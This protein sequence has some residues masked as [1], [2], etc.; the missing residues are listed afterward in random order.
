M[1]EVRAML[2]IPLI[3]VQLDDFDL[4]LQVLAV[5]AEC[6]AEVLFLS[7]AEI[8]RIQG[9]LGLMRVYL[10]ALPHTRTSPGCRIVL[11]FF[12]FNVNE[13]IFW[14]LPSLKQS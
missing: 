6:E 9:P 10:F 11:R 5:W 1:F 2:E 12:S 14:I 8:Y 7:I 13:T 4:I 3:L